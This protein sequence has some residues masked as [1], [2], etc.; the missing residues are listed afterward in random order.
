M[1]AVASCA[2]AIREGVVDFEG[3]ETVQR[4]LTLF[5]V[6]GTTAG[7]VFG[8]LT[9]SFYNSVIIVTATAI[10]SAV[11]C[12]PSWPAYHQHPIPW[13][14]HDAEKLKALY[15]QQQQ[16]AAGSEAPPVAPPSPLSAGKSK[17]GARQRKTDRQN[18]RAS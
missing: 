4:L 6:C 5:S 15:E 2:S 11:V 12:I 14:P 1:G 17:R 13:T 10:V 8:L 16:T 7:F 3:Q 18:N 9:E